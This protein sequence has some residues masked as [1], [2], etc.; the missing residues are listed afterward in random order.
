MSLFLKGLKMKTLHKAF[1]IGA[2][3]L[4]FG[5]GA[6]AMPA[7]AAE[8]PHQ[9][10]AATK[11]DPVKMQ[12]R[13]DRR[14]QRMHDALKITPAQEGAWQAYLSALKSNMPQRAE[15]DRAAFKSMP[16]P[17]RM[18][19]R[20]EMTKSHIIRMENNLA[21]TKTFYAQLTPEQQKL[22][23]EKAGRFGHRAH[24]HKM[25]HHH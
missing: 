2:T 17:E 22:F 15:F 12:E 4:G 21:A 25:R 18:E 14:A 7:V 10:Y 1:V 9:Q 20:I 5:F 3:V 16:A 8:G 23:D 13:M 24:A 11:F 19:K 6:A